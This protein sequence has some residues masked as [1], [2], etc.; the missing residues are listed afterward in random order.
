VADKPEDFK[1]MLKESEQAS[2]ALHLALSAKP[3]DLQAAD[4][5]YKSIAA[6]CSAC[7]KVYRD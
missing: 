5:A 7:H 4:T 1:R 2:K 3:I 6:S